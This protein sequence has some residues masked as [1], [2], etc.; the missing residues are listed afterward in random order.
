[1]FSGITFN[2]DLKGTKKIIKRKG[3]KIILAASG[4]MTGGRVLEYLKHYLSDK[5]ILSSLSGIRLKAPAEGHY[6]IMHM[7][8]RY[9]AS[10][11]RSKLMCKRSVTCQLMLIRLN[12][13]N[14]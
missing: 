5:K 3:S 10:I 1:M 7:S 12:C 8:S 4:M 9:T 6:W 14:G 2:K 13:F 11:I